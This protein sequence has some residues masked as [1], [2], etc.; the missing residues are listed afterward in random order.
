M[1]ITT[2][3]STIA[4]RLHFPLLVIAPR[5]FVALL[6][7]SM[8]VGCPLEEPAGLVDDGY[9]VALFPDDGAAAVPQ[10]VSLVVEIGADVDTPVDLF[11]TLQRDG[12][13]PVDLD[14]V[15]TSDALLLECTATEPLQDSANYAFVV[16]LAET[17]D[18]RVTSRFSTA[19]PLGAGYE[20]AAD[21]TV[22]QFGAG[23]YAAP[24]LGAAIAGGSPLLLVSQDVY[25]DEDIPVAGTNFVWG[26]GK[27]LDG[28]DSDVYAVTRNVG[29]PLASVTMIDAHGSI[30]GSSAHSYLPIWLDGAWHPV[31]VDDLVMRGSLD[32][33][34][35]TLPVSELSVEAN[36]PQISIDRI[37][38]QLDGP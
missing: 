8:L 25:D 17:P 3:T 29:Y 16:E 38:A 35:P 20:L 5:L 31:R 32:T 22:G 21:M 33:S 14:C 9:I 18:S 28:Q 12:G 2:G 27:L 19:H 34:D 30:F 26:P 6:T 15:A 11:A 23:E 10:E 1:D 24:V 13:A 37:M 7:P 4:P 36:V